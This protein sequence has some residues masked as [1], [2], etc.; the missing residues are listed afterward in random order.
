MP[1]GIGQDGAGIG[2]DDIHPCD[3]E[4]YRVARGCRRGQRA[5]QRTERDQEDVADLRTLLLQAL[6][7]PPPRGIAPRREVRTGRRRIGWRLVEGD[8]RGARPVPH[9]RGQHVAAPA[10]RRGGR[11]AGRPGA[12][13]TASPGPAR[14]PAR[15]GWARAAARRKWV[16]PR[17]SLGSVYRSDYAEP[18]SLSRVL[19]Y[20]HAV[21]PGRSA[22]TIQPKMTLGALYRCLARSPGHA[23]RDAGRHP[24]R[25][26]DLGRRRACGGGHASRSRSSSGRSMRT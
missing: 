10:G 26:A 22:A 20:G 5:R 18:R 1:G 14:S 17:P 2:I 23:T 4:T 9:R 7:T 19:G 25:G 6:E 24:L 16:V 12:A 13:G 15:P 11:R 3:T 8:Q 21:P